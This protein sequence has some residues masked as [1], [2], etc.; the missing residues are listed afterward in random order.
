MRLGD[1]PGRG[2]ALPGTVEQ[3][4]VSGIVRNQHPPL[5]CRNEQLLDIARS[6]EAPLPRRQHVVPF[7]AEQPHDLR[8]HVMI[9]VENRHPSPF[10]LE[11]HMI[12]VERE[13]LQDANR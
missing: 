5:L 3:D 11:R 4:E 13:A 2:P 7:M 12:T 10:T 9:G 8:R 6:R 1:P